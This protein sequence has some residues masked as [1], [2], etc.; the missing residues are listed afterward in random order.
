[1]DGDRVIRLG[2]G[3]RRMVGDGAV[4]LGLLD[5]LFPC[6]RMEGI[7]DGDDADG[8][9][10]G[11]LISRGRRMATVLPEKSESFDRMTPMRSTACTA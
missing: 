4:L 2:E 6:A 5:P 1:M 3:E 9:L 7:P 11:Y 10:L 8:G